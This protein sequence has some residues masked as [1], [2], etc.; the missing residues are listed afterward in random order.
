MIFFCFY[1]ENRGDL[2]YNKENGGEKV[3][4]EMLFETEIS[5]IRL[6]I[7]ADRPSYRISENSKTDKS[8]EALMEELHSHS[9]YELFFIPDDSMTI[10]T[11]DK[12]EVYNRK[13][14][15][16]PPRVNHCVES[17]AKSGYCLIFAIEKEY[18]KDGEIYRSVEE[19]LSREISAFEVDP[20]MAFYMEKL[21]ELIASGKNGD[22]AKHVCALLFL[23][24]F[25]AMELPTE[26]TSVASLKYRNYVNT[27]DQYISKHYSE[28]IRIDDLASELHLCSKQVSRII[29]KEYGMSLS[30]VVHSRR[31]SVACMLLKHTALNIGQIAE[32]VGYEY[33]N[34]F[35]RMFKDTYG[36]TP[37][38]YRA[39]Y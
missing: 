33:E 24:I 29:N 18:K 22:E 27:V 1:I 20:D 34:Y 31:L 12:T 16:I 15:I 35:F 26:K 3:L 32:S 8:S 10:I 6:S 37:A 38:E 36:V 13:A 14:V 28:Q 25:K 23:S 21:S 2:Y 5:D 17:W 19:R 9:F 30:Q 4:N 11:E 39:K 7:I